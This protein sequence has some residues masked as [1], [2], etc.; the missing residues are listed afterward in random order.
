MTRLAFHTDIQA[1]Q[2]ML[3]DRDQRFRVKITANGHSRH[4]Q[5]SSE[6]IVPIE[7]TYKDAAPDSGKI[8]EMLDRG[9][10]VIFGPGE[11]EIK[12]SPLFDWLIEIVGSGNLQLEANKV[13]CGHINLLRSRASGDVVGRIDAIS[14]KITCGR[15]EATIEASLPYDLLRINVTPGFEQ[16]ESRPI[17]MPVNLKAW[18]GQ[19]L[20]DLPL[21]DPIASVFGY[22]RKGDQLSL[23]CFVPGRRLMSG[24]LDFTENEPYLGIATAIEF[25][26]KARAV[27]TVGHV[28]P[29]LPEGFIAQTHLAE[30]DDLYKILIG[31]GRKYRTPRAQVE[32]TVERGGLRKYLREVKDASGPGTL[33]LFR[34]EAFPFLGETVTVSPLE[35]I[36]TNAQLVNGVSSLIQQLRRSPSKREFRLLWKATEITDTILRRKSDEGEQPDAPLDLGKA[37]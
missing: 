24:A 21:F 11:I 35:R 17:S 31:E 16:R 34:D 25:L 18:T 1:E 7:F 2:R 33:N 22:P 19:R 14:C 29:I 37:C 27:A 8:E 28:N 30:I 10:P 13:I 36:V 26:R 20:L 4:Y 15:K 12:G 5:F 9:V 3:E 6:E 23:E 32:I